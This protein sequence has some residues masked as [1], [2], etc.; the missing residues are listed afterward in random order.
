MHDQK[1]APITFL[2]CIGDIQ[3]RTARQGLYGAISYLIAQL[4]WDSLAVSQCQESVH[5]EKPKSAKKQQE[6]LRR[7][8]FTHD[9]QASVH[10]ARDCS[11][12]TPNHPVML[13]HCKAHQLGRTQKSFCRMRQYTRR[14]KFSIFSF[15]FSPSLIHKGKNCWLGAFYPEYFYFKSFSQAWQINSCA[16]KG[17]HWIHQ[18]WSHGK[19]RNPQN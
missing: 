16:L 5:I 15:R 12:L 8:F 19:S 6:P 18:P 9:T 1:L 11:L 3:R 14:I 2:A 4:S 13:K 17:W 10:I 7:A